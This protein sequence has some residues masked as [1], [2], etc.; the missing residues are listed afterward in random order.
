MKIEIIERNYDVGKRLT[1]LITKKLEK[2]AT[3]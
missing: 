3:F 1:E 2:C